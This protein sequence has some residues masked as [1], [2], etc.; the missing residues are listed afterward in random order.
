MQGSHPVSMKVNLNWR[1]CRT[2]VN[3]SRIRALTLYA[4]TRIWTR[5][6]H[7]RTYIY[8]IH[9]TSIWFHIIELVVTYVFKRDT[10][11]TCRPTFHP[12]NPT[13]RP[14]PHLQVGNRLTQLSKAVNKISCARPWQSTS[15]ADCPSWFMP[16]Y[17][18]LDILSP[19]CM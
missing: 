6:V 19:W 4:V 9:I 7:L 12:I 11:S 18:D 10:C 8:I 16:S 3:N 15:L 13:V 2:L 5:C 1:S 17:T 14:S